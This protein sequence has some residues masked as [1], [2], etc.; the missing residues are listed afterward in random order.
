M[1]VARRIAQRLLTPDVTERLRRLES[2]FQRLPIYFVTASTSKRRPILNSVDVRERFIQFGKEGDSHGARLGPYVLMPDHLHAFVVIDDE[3]LR[4][5]AWMQ[6]SEECAVE[7]TS[8]ERRSITTLAE[9]I[10]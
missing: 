1:T 10:F 8:P 4:L 3:R 2:T 7:S 5:S 9:R 6:I